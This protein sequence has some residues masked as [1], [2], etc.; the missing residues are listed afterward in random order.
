VKEA[1]I[2]VSLWALETATGS[3][4]KKQA[5]SLS[6]APSSCLWKG[7]SSAPEIAWEGKTTFS[8]RSPEEPRKSRFSFP[9]DLRA[10][11]E[12]SSIVDEPGRGLMPF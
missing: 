8:R 10:L 6:V 9:G 3:A 2:P 5:S 11:P 1:G 4:P 12:V 7:I